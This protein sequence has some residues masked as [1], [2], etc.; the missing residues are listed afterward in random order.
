MRLGRTL[1]LPVPPRKHEH[2]R[3]K[4]NENGAPRSRPTELRL[5]YPAPRPLQN[6]DNRERLRLP[7][8]GTVWITADR[9]PL[10]DALAEALENTAFDAR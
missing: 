2:D 8:G 3:P 6:Q 10:T 4:N 9:S 5:L 7:A 1:A